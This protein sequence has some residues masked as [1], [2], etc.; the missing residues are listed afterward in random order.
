[1]APEI[2]STINVDCPADLL[3]TDRTGSVASNALGT[4]RGGGFIAYSSKG[5]SY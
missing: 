2:N 3:Y 1:M 4:K 5:Y